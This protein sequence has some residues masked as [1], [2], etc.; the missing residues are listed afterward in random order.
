MRAEDIVKE[1]ESLEHSPAMELGTENGILSDIFNEI[2]SSPL[3]LVLVFAIGFLI[4]KIVKGRRDAAHERQAASS[5]PLP[6]LKKRDMSLQELRQYDGSDPTGRILVA[7]NSKVFDVT[8]GKRF[9][10]PGTYLTV[11]LYDTNM[12]LDCRLLRRN[13]RV[14]DVLRVGILLHAS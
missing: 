11:T 1:A 8:R 14:L 5:P 7:V 3:N 2:I 13:K 4:Y 9:Y 6:K 10:G 12:Y